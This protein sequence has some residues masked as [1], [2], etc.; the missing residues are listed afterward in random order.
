M[1]TNLSKNDKMSLQKCRQ[2]Q[3]FNFVL[4][5]ASITS[6][7][8]HFFKL[9]SGDGESLN[10]MYVLILQTYQNNVYI[11]FLCKVSIPLEPIIF[12]I[13]TTTSLPFLNS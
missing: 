11:I 3:I 13:T 2:V 1:I 8:I 6:L 7:V 12:Q 4:Q 10:D 5:L 9:L